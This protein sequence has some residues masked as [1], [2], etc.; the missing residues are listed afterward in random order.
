MSYYFYC[1]CITNTP[2]ARSPGTACINHFSKLK[3][4]GLTCIAKVP[5]PPDAP[6]IKT[7]QCN[8]KKKKKN[9]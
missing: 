5:T 3:K 8:A 6:K 7:L 4:K 2:A 9:L 1:L